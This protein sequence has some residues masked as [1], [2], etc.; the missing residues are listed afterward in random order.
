M[1]KIVITEFMDQNAVESLASQFE[2]IYDKDLV[3]NPDELLKAASDCQA[4]IVRNRTQVKG[5]LLDS[6]SL[7]VVGRLGVGLDNIDVGKCREKGIEVIPA[8]GANDMSVAEYVITGLLMLMR[9]SY[10]N[11]KEVGAGEWPRE[12]LIGREVSGKTL[13]LIGFGSIGRETALRAEALGMHVIAFDPYIKPDDPVWKK[14]NVAR[15]SL[16][17]LLQK[18]DVVSL[19]VPLTESTKHIINSGN[20][21]K[22]KAGAIIINAARGGVVD[23]L[24][25]AQALKEGR[26]GGALVD[27]FE[28]EPL[29]AGSPLADAPNC[30]LT[31][32]VAG[33]T[34]ESNVRV[35]S[36]I[37]KKVA[38]SL[39][40]MNEA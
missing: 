20:I 18:S 37:A 4:L 35:S 38:E 39:K 12:K 30:I 23:E 1:S 5:K 21:S 10:M 14:Y 31:P 22:M 33:V 8:T 34:K 36:L 16:D 7:K 2:V 9:G 19:H 28:K 3:N 29:P 11:S 6:P 27:V 26:I 13:G 24:A 15:V 40:N 25:L 32:H 17:E